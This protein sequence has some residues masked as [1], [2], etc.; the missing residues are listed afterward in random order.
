MQNC[1]GD[2]KETEEAISPCL[3]WYKSEAT[4]YNPPWC[5]V[6]SEIFK[7]IFPNQ[8]WM[9]LFA[10][11]TKIFNFYG[12]R[13]VFKDLIQDKKNNVHVILLIQ[14]FS[15]LNIFTWLLNIKN[16]TREFNAVENRC[17]V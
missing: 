13:S 17:F 3:L 8:L 15:I 9:Y 4:P 6:T 10:I 14:F 1:V 16:F 7:N 5:N 2:P 11:K 12:N